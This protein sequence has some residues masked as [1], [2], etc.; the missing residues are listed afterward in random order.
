MARCAVERLMHLAG[1]EGVVPG[2]RVRTTIPADLSRSVAK[3]TRLKYVL[4]PAPL[5]SRLADAVGRSWLS[6]RERR[7]RIEQEGWRWLSS[8]ARNA[9]G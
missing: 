4:R 8:S 3:G 6:G 2:K 7:S 9:G 5:S 1:L